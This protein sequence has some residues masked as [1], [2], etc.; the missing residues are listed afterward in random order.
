ME[1]HTNINTAQEKTEALETKLGLTVVQVS[2]GEEKGWRRV[3]LCATL[4][5][6]YSRSRHANPEVD[7]P[8]N[9]DAQSLQYKSCI[10]NKP[11]LQ[12]I[13]MYLHSFCCAA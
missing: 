4:R 13:P 6:E 5:Y 7:G 10:L 1:G 3:S 11:T 9:T 2:L 8:D 12:S